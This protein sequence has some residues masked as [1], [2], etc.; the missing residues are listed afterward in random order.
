MLSSTKMNL[1][2]YFSFFYRSSGEHG[3]PV[4]DMICFM[5]TARSSRCAS[6][7]PLSPFVGIPVGSVG[8]KG[9]GDYGQ[10][11]AKPLSVPAL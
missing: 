3:E 9:M 2:S 6:C 8:G 11:K 5:K 1:R 4:A 10:I 7:G